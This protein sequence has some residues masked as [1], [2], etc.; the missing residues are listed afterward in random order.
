M[1]IT[2]QVEASCDVTIN[3]WNFYGRNLHAT[4]GNET[5]DM[6]NDG[7]QGRAYRVYM[8]TSCR[9]VELTR[10]CDVYI[11]SLEQYSKSII[12]CLDRYSK[13]NWSPH[14]KK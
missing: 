14:N 10:M 4:W 13:F 6:L 7:V 1:S 5:E 2:E 8:C 11:L 12:Y 3:L 9:Y